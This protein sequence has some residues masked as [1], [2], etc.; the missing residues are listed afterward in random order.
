[1]KRSATYGIAFVAVA[2]M[3]GWFAI[4][5]IAGAGDLGGVSAAV[6]M[7]LVIAVG[8]AACTAAVVLPT[9]PS[10]RAFRVLRDRFQDASVSRILGSSDFLIGV[11][12]LLGRPTYPLGPKYY[13]VVVRD[14]S[15]EFWP[16]STGVPLLTLHAQDIVDVAVRDVT[17]PSNVTRASV[18]VETS[19]DAGRT[20]VL[21]LM[22][23]RNTGT[24]AFPDGG[25]AAANAL[26]S[27]ISGARSKGKRET[28]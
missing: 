23:M 3:A 16:A 25:S 21:P 22:V 10:L 7:F 2:V 5:S 14:D 24:G 12:A 15:V 26:A 8:V 18:L 4:R 17:S 20:V 13:V 28:T 1:M 27:A 19:T 11:N 6:V 9:R